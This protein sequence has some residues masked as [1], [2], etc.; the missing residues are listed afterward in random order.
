MARKKSHSKYIPVLILLVIISAV[1]TILYGEGYLNLGSISQLPK[2]KV[3]EA[4][5]LGKAQR[6]DIYCVYNLLPIEYG[7]MKDGSDYLVYGVEVT[8]ALSDNEI[9]P[10]EKDTFNGTAYVIPKFVPIT[11][12]FRMKDRNGEKL[13]TFVL[14]QATADSIKG[15]NWVEIEL[16]KDVKL[17]L[18]NFYLPKQ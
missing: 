7:V 5:C 1:L 2:G 3:A 16:T 15:A 13:Q 6:E 4:V 18:T 12:G 8:K 11:T 14:D 17:R 9:A 10:N